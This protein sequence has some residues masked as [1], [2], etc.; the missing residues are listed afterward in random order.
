[1]AS[2]IVRGAIST[3]LEDKTLTIQSQNAE[4]MLNCGNKLLQSVIENE[5]NMEV[6]DKFCEGLISTI[7][8]IWENV[9]KKITSLSTKKTRFWSLFHERRLDAL[10]KLWYEL[11]KKLQLVPDD[12]F[13][14]SVS[15]ELFQQLLTIE[16]T[17]EMPTRE[18]EPII[19]TPDELNAM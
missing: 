2:G 6:F 3:V 13:L 11:F 9:P 14:Q 10:P 15:Q 18:Q 1:M 19:L 8:S 12:L 16:I 5:E 7:S 17:K 4:L